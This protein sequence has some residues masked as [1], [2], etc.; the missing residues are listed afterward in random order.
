MSLSTVE[1]IMG[2]IEVASSESRLAVLK[3]GTKFLDVFFADTI[4]GQTKIKE[5]KKNLIG[6]FDKTMNQRTIKGQLIRA[7]PD[8]VY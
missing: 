8:Y 7:L 4:T 2:R 3:T 1:I 5:N 6:I